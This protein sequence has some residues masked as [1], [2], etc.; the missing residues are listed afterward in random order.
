MP[1]EC[2]NSPRAPN[3]IRKDNPL[4]EAMQKRLISRKRPKYV[5]CKNTFQYTGQV[6][7]YNIFSMLVYLKC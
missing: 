4:K 1:Y 7:Y 3:D 2:C 5:D 6:S